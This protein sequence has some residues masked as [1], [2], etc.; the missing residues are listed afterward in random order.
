MQE[1]IIT[2][3]KL[4]IL[5][6]KIRSGKTSFLLDRFKE[7]KK[8]AGILTITLNGKRTFYNL[9]SREYIRF[10][11]D[12]SFDGRVQKIGRYTFDDSAFGKVEEIID[13]TD[14]SAIDCFILDEAG[15]LE[16]NGKGFISVIKKFVERADDLTVPVIIVV[17]E[18]CVEQIIEYFSMK[19]VS[20]L[21]KE[22]F[23][24]DI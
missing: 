20:I 23:T 14:F 10:E 4:F 8:A 1:N 21:R 12:D 7:N 24:L 9:T 3:S 22:R 11:V 2:D 18:E 13:N 15:P 16:L 17:R 19:N 6:G 5:T